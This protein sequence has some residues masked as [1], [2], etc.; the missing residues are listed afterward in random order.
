MILLTYSQSAS[1]SYPT[2]TLTKLTSTLEIEA[3]R[4][5][6]VANSDDSYSLVA[7]SDGGYLLSAVTTNEIRYD[8]FI[9]LAK[10]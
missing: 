10:F 8:S 7:L 4:T 3:R 6:R 9:Y 1:N 2:L 5:F